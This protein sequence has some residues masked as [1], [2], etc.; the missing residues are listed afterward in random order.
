MERRYKGFGLALIRFPFDSLLWITAAALC[1]VFYFCT[2][3]FVPGQALSKVFSKRCCVIIIIIIII[4][5]IHVIPATLAQCNNDSDGGL[6]AYLRAHIIC[7]HVDVL[8][9][10]QVERADVTLPM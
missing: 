4:I 2:S 3:A 10:P 1:V 6:C 9:V 8:N 7:P 5:M